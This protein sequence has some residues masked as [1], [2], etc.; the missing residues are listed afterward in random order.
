MSVAE[1][2]HISTGVLIS[3]LQLASCASCGVTCP[4]LLAA[5]PV[6]ASFITRQ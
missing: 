5:G 1:S 3:S 4:S 6:G 2:A